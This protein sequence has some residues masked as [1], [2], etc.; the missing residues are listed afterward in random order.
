MFNGDAGE[1]SIAV[2]SVVEEASHSLGQHLM[3]VGDEA[4]LGPT[5]TFAAQ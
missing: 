3:V 1:V 2:L 5:N 4:V